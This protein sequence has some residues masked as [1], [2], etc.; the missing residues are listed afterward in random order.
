MTEEKA[1]TL[2][3]QKDTAGLSWFITRY[4]GYVSAIVWNI[5]GSHLTRQDAEEIVADVFLTLWQCCQYPQTDRVKAYLGSIAR[6]RA[7]DRL[8]KHKIEPSLEY[9]RLE[10]SAD[11]PEEFILTQET[12]ARLRQAMEDMPPIY[13][14]IFIRHY[15]YYQTAA[16]IGKDMGLKPDLVRQ[17]LK[18]GRDFLRHYLTEGEYDYEY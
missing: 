4:T 11:G 17:R 13:R 7:I 12:H 8:R 15:Y 1:L 3:R 10:L 5:V 18:R 9:D 6:S 2:M 14:E 16:A